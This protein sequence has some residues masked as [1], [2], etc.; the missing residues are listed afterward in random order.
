MT[1]S[2]RRAISRS[3]RPKASI[4][5]RARVGCFCLIIAALSN[6]CAAPVDAQHVRGDLLGA[7]EFP[8]ITGNVLCG[9]LWVDENPRLT[10][11]RRIPLHLVI[12]R[13]SGATPVKDP[14]FVLVGGPG[15]AATA[16]LRYWHDDWERV[17]RDIVFVD[18]RGTGRSNRLNCRLPGGN[19]DA[20]G[21]FDE[22]FSPQTF[23]ECRNRLERSADLRLYTTPIAMDD[24]DLVRRTLGYDRINLYGASYGTRAA[25]VYLRKYG[26]HV[27]SIVLNGVVPPEYTNPLFHA[28]EA[29]RAL[30]ALLADCEHDVACVT[31]FPDIE[32]KLHTLFARLDVQPAQ[33]SLPSGPGKTPAANV[34]LSRRAF[35]EALRILMYQYDKLRLIPLL[36]Q[37]VRTDGDFRPLTRLA[38][39]R[40]REMRGGAWG[41]LLSVICSEDV[42]RI[43]EQ[44]IVLHTHN[45]GLR[46]TRVRAQLA[47]CA[48]WPRGEIDAA[49]ASPVQSSVPV[50]LLSGSRDPVTP[51]EW[52]ELASRTLPNSYHLVVWGAHGI[53]G[54]CVNHI[55]KQFLDTASAEKLDTSCVRDMRRPAFELQN[56]PP[57]RL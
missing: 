30:D 15:G 26:E 29:Q 20:Q 41:M 31:A 19:N 4:A 12:L 49:Y 54:P 47:V 18:Q 55:V 3:S 9:S 40:H 1:E 53:G 22:V 5:L 46:D 56:V 25:L 13:A 27:R 34:V 24:L 21:Y 39:E 16:A 44:D 37:R 32:K 43:S 51:S 38:L 35:A 23:I 14:I 48:E 8:G 7:C 6:V 17:D 33:V 57:E 45:T 52:A 42:P 11:A 50:L 10:G 2:Q 28:R 36:V